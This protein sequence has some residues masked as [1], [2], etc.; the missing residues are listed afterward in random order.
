MTSNSGKFIATL[1][2]FTC[3]SVNTVLNNVIY[4]CAARGWHG[5][6]HTFRKPWFMDWSMFL[7][8]SLGIFNTQTFRTFTCAPHEP[9]GKLRGWSLFRQVSL[10]G[11][12]DLL[13]TYLSN[14]ALLYLAPS[15]WQMLR[16]SELIFT[17][18][19]AIVYRHKKLGL[20]D[21]VGVGVTVVGVAVV[22]ISSILTEPHPSST[23]H[24]P[25]SMQIM[26]MILILVAMGLAA[27]QTVL[28][29]ELLHD[30]DATAC[31]LVSYEG[32]WGV[33]FTSLFAL[34]LAQIMPEN[35]GEGLFEHT[36]ESFQMLGASL[37]LFGLWFAFVV[38]VFA[39]NLSGLALCAYTSAISRT[40]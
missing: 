25:A 24:A 18:T 26:A 39:Y 28:E 4:N 16:G 34:P 14:I 38:A 32:L 10:P 31:E 13:G 40:I 3:G 17:A 30:V 33:Y 19:W 23:T 5:R 27:L 15:I 2:F 29:E 20:A 1:T 37:K 8:M 6:F 12:C 7:G 36:L 22:G 35:A 9:G 11:L 21:W